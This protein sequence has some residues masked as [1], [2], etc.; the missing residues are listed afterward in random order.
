M[1]KTCHGQVLWTNAPL[2]QVGLPESTTLQ[3]INDDILLAGDGRE[4][5]S[6]ES[7]PKDAITTSLK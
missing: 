6:Q 4:T 5:A 2:P 1:D 7:I 3:E